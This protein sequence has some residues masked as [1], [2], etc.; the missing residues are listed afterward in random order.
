MSSLPP[1][2]PVPGARVVWLLAADALADVPPG[3]RDAPSFDRVVIAGEDLRPALAALSGVEAEVVP[4]PAE[5]HPGDRGMLVAGPQDYV[6]AVLRALL[7]MPNG[8]ARF[9]VLPGQ[10]CS[11]QVLPDRA[12]LTHLNP[13]RSLG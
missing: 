1:Y 11:V 5:V 6:E 9:R 10:P 2:N 8:T 3:L 4:D 13:G 12:I 7:G